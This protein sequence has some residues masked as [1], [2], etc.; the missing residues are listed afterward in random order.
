M[1]VLRKLFPGVRII[2][3]TTM[4]VGDQDPTDIES[5]NDIMRRIAAREDIPVD[6][7]CGLM[8]GRMSTYDVGDGLHL[9]DE[10]NAI[11]AAK[12]SESIRRYLS[13]D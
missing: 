1:T 13:Q 10:G 11:V 8:K 4:P 12:V 7:L 6:D 5:Y 9:N 3:G 2:F